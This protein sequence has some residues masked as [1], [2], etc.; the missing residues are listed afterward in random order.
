[1]NKSLASDNCSGV[2]PKIL[3]YI[4]EVNNGHCSAYGEDSYTKEAVEEV[5]KY[6]G[7][8]K[9]YF[10]YNG[11]GANV[12]ALDAMKGR[13]SSVICADTAH[14][15]SDETG[16][17]SK[18]TG[19]QLFPIQN[20]DGKLDLKSVKKY[21]S[22]KNSFH[23]P[24]PSIISISQTT[25]TGTVYSL[26]EIKEIGKFA[27]ENGM[28]FHMDGARI[29]N[30]A[31]SLGCSFKEMTV[32]LGVDVLCFGGTKNGLMMGEVIIFFNKDLAENFLKLRKQDLQLNS[33]MRFLSAQFIPYLRDNIWYESAKNANDM[34]DYLSKELKDNGLIIMNKVEANT[35]FAILP[36]GIIKSLQEFCHFHIWD[37]DKNIVRFV[38][39]FDIEKSDIDQFISKLKSLTEEI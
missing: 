5:K 32:D 15:F 13:A 16:A 22:Y 9:A 29:S 27:K 18:I 31:A 12:L 23:K 4:V 38:T 25:E 6:F 20:I 3:Q 35:I 36:K 10:V 7:D 8:V 26:E 39:S 11:T 33:K 17:P 34:A 30:A 2:H 24:N 21:I 37:D 28:L 19:M 1:M 14:I